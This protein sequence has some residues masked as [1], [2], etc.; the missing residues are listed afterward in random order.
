M[1]IRRLW[2]RM[3]I[4]LNIAGE[5]CVSI[6]R[7]VASESRPYLSYPSTHRY[8]T[9]AIVDARE[10]YCRVHEKRFMIGNER[11]Y[12]SLA[13]GSVAKKLEK[14]LWRSGERLGLDGNTNASA[15]RKM[16]SKDN[17]VSSSTLTSP[18]IQSMS[19]QTLF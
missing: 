6:Q 14:A 4:L 8:Q 18:S 13:V 16:T 9:F 2:D 12:Y 17:G 11:V 10:K 19:I 15:L 7:S 5:I 1:E 3:E